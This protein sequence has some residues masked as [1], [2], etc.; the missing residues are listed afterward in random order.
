MF[1]N[2]YVVSEEPT[3]LKD[4]NGFEWNGLYVYI[5]PETDFVLN[6]KCLIIGKAANSL[7]SRKNIDDIAEELSRCPCFD[8]AMKYLDFIAGRYIVFFKDEGETLVLTD[9][10]GFKRGLF[11]N[12]NGKK[13]ITSSENFAAKIL[14]F[15]V[16]VDDEVSDLINNENYKK[17][18]SP[19]FGLSSYDD[20][21]SFI[22]PNHYLIWSSFSIKRMLAPDYC[23][24]D[25]IENVAEM[26]ENTMIS[27]S[28]NYKLIQPVTA[29][30]D[31]RVLLSA[32]R[33]VR[34]KI[35]YYVF[36]EKDGAHEDV[37]IPKELASANKFTLDVISRHPISD[38]FKERLISN[39]L[40]ARF[41]PKTA[42][43]Y[44][45]LKNTPRDSVNINGNGAEI[46]RCYYGV[47]AIRLGPKSLSVLSG[48]DKWPLL[49]R[50]ISSW[51]IKTGALSYAKKNRISILDL[52]YWEQRMAKWGSMYP[53]E[54]DVAIDE[55]SPFSNRK[56]IF[57]MLRESKSDRGGP[58]FR[59]SVAIINN[60]EPSLNN[61]PINPDS[62][63]S[64][65][66]IS[67]IKKHSILMI[68]AKR[69]KRSL[70]T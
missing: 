61:F 48:V 17:T 55:I 57:T 35:S 68:L 69:I 56:L 27:L 45:H 50:G 62:S 9:A 2:Q 36:G 44:H 4:I 19:W 65:G 53:L 43:I 23:F 15:K 46:F 49:E 26:L 31:S 70:S 51:Y 67:F 18:E 64:A 66:I 29:G 20:R 52:F 25:G 3:L 10:C 37:R 32:G 11:M 30:V 8:D 41:L 47:S 54:Q 12:H 13:L 42:N 60:L 38:C 16:F 39:V 22:I 14:N 40:G 24:S 28:E 6:D 59:S 1:K 5:G 7:N 63:K 34:N 58:D 21:F 33:S